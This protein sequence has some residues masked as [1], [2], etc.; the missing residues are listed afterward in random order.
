MAPA[1]EVTRNVFITGGTGYIGSRLI[2][3]LI[4]RGHTVRALVR[5]GSEEKLAR[6]AVAVN[7][8]SLEGS[9]FVRQNCAERHFHSARRRRPSIAIENRSVPGSRLRS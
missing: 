6:G 2:A 9:T 8:N 5:S 4:A 1:G 3:E 7:G